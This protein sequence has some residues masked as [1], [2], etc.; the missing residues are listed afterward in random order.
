VIGTLVAGK[1]VRGAMSQGADTDVSSGHVGVLP[2]RPGFRRLAGGARDWLR[3]ELFLRTETG[4]V[5]WRKILLGLAFVVAGTAVALARTRGPGALNTIWIEDAKFL[6]PQA[7]THSFWVCAN[8]PISGYYQES[9]RL[10]TELA[11]Q[12][13]VRLMPAVMSVGAAAQYACYG[14]V[15]YIASGPH[16]RSPWLRLLVAAPVCAIPLAYTQVDVDLVTVQFI[17]LY[18]AFWALLWIPGTRAGRILSPLVMLSVAT[19]T[20]LVVVYAPLVAA[21]L[22]ADRSKNAVFLASCWLAGVALEMSPT[23]RG[24]A[25][26]DKYPYNGPLFVLE[27]YAS[28]VVPRALFGESALGGPGTSYR[29]NPVPLHI[30]NQAGHNILIAAAWLVVAVVLVAAAT[31]LTSPDWPLVVTAAIFSVGVFTAELLV[32]VP[33][34]QPRYAVAPA[35]LLYVVIVAALRPRAPLGPESASQSGPNG[36][37]GWLLVAGFTVLL[38]VAVALN[39][40]VT[41]GRTNSPPWTTV[42][43]QAKA[44][45]AR[46]G[47]TAYTYTHEW[48]QTRIPCSKL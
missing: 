31:R 18:G 10:V 2:A 14:L 6:L 8:T 9:A 29:G 36:D 7:L 23:L 27:N 30:I 13:P 15:A 43:T 35:L 45:C 47:V 38:A 22:I 48:W 11:V 19:T 1:V 3:A 39:F 4:P 40:R 32:N 24:V 20:V 12:F 26:H 28:R 25:E 41:N 16:L 42:V 17:A 46:P 34:V 33:T 44:A 5:G 21:R 37:V